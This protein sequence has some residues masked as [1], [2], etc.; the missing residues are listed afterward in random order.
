MHHKQLCPATARSKVEVFS[1]LFLPSHNKSANPKT[2]GMRVSSPHF[3]VTLE[4]FCLD[5]VET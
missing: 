1:S 4:S 5:A 2:E 3:P